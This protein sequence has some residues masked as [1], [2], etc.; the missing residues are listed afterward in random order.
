[1][2]DYNKLGLNGLTLDMIYLLKKRVY[3]I[4]AVTDKTIKVKY[5]STII[6]TK[7]FEQYINLYIL[8]FIKTKVKVIFI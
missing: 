3:D 8:C 2:P 4:S 7:N 5:N 6:P 1:M